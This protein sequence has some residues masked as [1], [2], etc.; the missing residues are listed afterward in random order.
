MNVRLYILPLLLSCAAIK[1]VAMDSAKPDQAI[2]ALCTRSISCP[3]DQVTSDEI[4]NS[5]RSS[6]SFH[7]TC[8]LARLLTPCEHSA[9]LGTTCQDCDDDFLRL[10]GS[11]P[12]QLHDIIT[13]LHARDAHLKPATPLLQLALIATC[14]ARSDAGRWI[15][16]GQERPQHFERLRKA[17]H[18]SYN[19]LSVLE[20][21]VTPETCKSV[22]PAALP[23][24]SC[25]Y[26][27]SMIH[28]ADLALNLV[29]H[30]DGERITTACHAA[31]LKKHLSEH[32]CAETIKITS[33][34]PNV[35]LAHAPCYKI[36]TFRYPFV[37]I[38]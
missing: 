5:P 4:C 24:V 16:L 34:T 29:T 10:L 12:R 33:S 18:E 20:K 38:E 25:L 37:P 15:L 21:L 19:N 32:Y 23:L 36:V 3:E 28:E 2:C 27:A 35:P 14:A 6:V 30:Q 22:S 7:I 31:C 9:A 26:C 11:L 8:A 13:R 17:L 1:L